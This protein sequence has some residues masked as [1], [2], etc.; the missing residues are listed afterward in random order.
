M[1]ATMSASTVFAAKP[2]AA[3]PARRGLRVQ[4]AAYNGAYAEELVQTAVSATR[5]AQRAMRLQWWRYRQQ[6]STPWCA[7]ATWP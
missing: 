1:A 5:R 2:V 3:R 4:A 6:V 7:G